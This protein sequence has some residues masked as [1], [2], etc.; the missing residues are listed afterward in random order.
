MPALNFI[1]EIIST[2]TIIVITNVRQA[3]SAQVSQFLKQT[4]DLEVVEIVDANTSTLPDSHIN[5]VIHF[6]GFDKPSLAQTLYHTSALHRLM[7]YCLQH[8]AKFILVLP[9]KSSAQQQTAITLAQQFA[10]DFDLK[11]TITT[12]PDNIETSQAAEE[13]IHTFIHSFKIP[14]KSI[15]PQPLIIT[16]DK[17]EKD[18]Y[19]VKAIIG[20]IGI[21]LL[22]FLVFA[23]GVVILI[24]S[25]GC[26]RDNLNSGNWQ[27]AQNCGRIATTTS[28]FLLLESHWIPEFNTYDLFIASGRLG[29]N[30]QALG[31]T[32][33]L[34]SSGHYEEANNLLPSVLEQLAYS[35]AELRKTP[36]SEA[37]VPTISAARSLLTKANLV[38]PSLQNIQMA[39]K[40]KWLILLQ[41]SDELRPTGGFIDNF[42]LVTLEN[43]AVTDVQLYDTESTD[44]LLRGQVD[45]PT[46]FAKISRQNNWYLRDSNW[47]PDF[48]KSAAKAAWFVSKELDV[49]IDGVVGVNLQLERQLARLLNIKSDSESKVLAGDLLTKLKTLSKKQQHQVEVFLMHQLETR[50]LE[51]TALDDGENFALTHWDGGLSCCALDTF[52]IVDSNVGVNKVNS[53]IVTA[54]KLGITKTTEAINYRFD[55]SY[56]NNS[57]SAAWP[58]G[59]YANYVRLLVPNY[60]TLDQMIIDGQSVKTDNITQGVNSGFAVWGTLIN[61]PISSTKTLTILAHRNLPDSPKPSYSLQWLNQPGAPPITLTIASG[62]EIGY[63]AV[64]SQ[65]TEI[66]LKLN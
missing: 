31:Q 62:S 50:Q 7:D 13:I 3:I 34:I 56:T 44:G 38:L 59:D 27:P 14:A 1:S 5:V 30:L 32:G 4:K 15:S 16:T 2:K 55:L 11:Y 22:P 24:V 52:Y 41:D 28:K 26:G 58:L 57:P 40:Q 63:N 8:R 20:F 6:A 60:F 12:I 61:I 18:K 42:A 53:Q 9:E 65:P 23:I 46:D 45:P 35:E 10:A 49:K 25:L 36:Q 33:D 66:K 19:F 21:L 43:G 48:P 39:A 29:Q 17:V 64:L 54:Y 47:D 51:I 37:F